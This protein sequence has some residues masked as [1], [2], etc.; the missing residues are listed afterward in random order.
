MLAV[1]FG[2]RLEYKSC[3][4]FEIVIIV[5]KCV[6]IINTQYYYTGR[7]DT[8]WKMASSLFIIPRAGVVGNNCYVII[9]LAFRWHFFSTYAMRHA[10]CMLMRLKL[11][12]VQVNNVVY[13]HLSCH[14]SEQMLVI[15]YYRTYTDK[16]SKR[17]Y[18][19]RF[20]QNRFYAFGR[21]FEIHFFFVWNC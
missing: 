13:V 11:P 6:Y 15:S 7:V 12:T 18:R 17:D 4:A 8:V 16:Q 14:V 1:R 20:K 19:I 5:N 10:R 21:G 3:F 9:I 2:I